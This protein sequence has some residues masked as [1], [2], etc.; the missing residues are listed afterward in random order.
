M[1][2][3]VGKDR[4]MADTAILS[5]SAANAEE[6]SQRGVKLYDDGQRVVYEVRSGGSTTLENGVHPWSSA[7]TEEL[8]Q[9]VGQTFGDQASVTVTRTRPAAAGR[10]QAGTGE[11]TAPA[12]AHRD[13]VLGPRGKRAP[14]PPG[15]GH[16]GEAAQSPPAPAGMAV[17]VVYVG[18]GTPAVLE[19][20]GTAQ[21]DVF[22]ID[23]DDDR[24]LR[25]KT[26]TDVSVTDGNAADLV[27]GRPQ[28]VSSELP[29][30]EKEESSVVELPPPVIQRKKRCRCFSL[31][32]LSDLWVKGTM[33]MEAPFPNTQMENQHI[34]CPANEQNGF[35]NR[36]DSTEGEAMREMVPLDL[37][38]EED[39]CHSA[40][41]INSSGP[42]S[43]GLT[44]IDTSDSQSALVPDIQTAHIKKDEVEGKKSACT[45]EDSYYRNPNGHVKMVGQDCKSPT[46]IKKEA[47][48]ELRAFQEEKPSKLFDCSSEKEPIRVTKVRD[49]E[50]ME[51]LERERQELIHSQAV[52][53]NPGIATKWW[54]PPQIK[55]IEEELD[56]D[57]LES[58]RKYQERKKKLESSNMQQ[59]DASFIP[60]EAIRKEDLLIEERNFSTTQNQLQ[61]EEN[62]VEIRG[63][64]TVVTPELCSG[65][66]FSG[67]AE[68]THAEKSSSSLENTT[69]DHVHSAQEK[70]TEAKTQRADEH[71]TDTTT[72]QARTENELKERKDRR[73]NYGDFTCAQAGVTV[74]EDPEL[75]SANSSCH[76]EEIDSGLDDLSVQSQD[77]APQELL[78]N[79]FSIDNVSDSGASNE[80]T[81]T[82]LENSLGDFSLP[83]TPQAT[84]PV[85]GEMG[86]RTAARS[87]ISTSPSSPR[88]FMT[89]EPVEYHTT[90]PVQKATQQ[91]R[92]TTSWE[93]TESQKESLPNPGRYEEVRNETH[94]GESSGSS[95]GKSCIQQ[96]SQ[97]YDHKSKYDPPQ[98][99]SPVQEK[100]DVAQEIPMKTPPVCNDTFRPLTVGGS[101][102]PQASEKQQFSYFS[103]Y[104]EA[105]ELRSTASLTRHREPE[106]SSVP[107]RLRSHK[108]RTLSRIEEEIRAAQEREQELKRQRQT[109]GPSTAPGHKD[110]TSNVPTRL[111]VTAKTA[112]GK[113]HCVAFTPPGQDCPNSPT[114]SDVSSEGSEGG[115]RPKNF[116]Q[117]LMED[118]EIHKVKRKDKME[119]NR[120]LEATRITRHKS[121]MA[122]QWEAGAYTNQ[123]EEEE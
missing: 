78:S 39:S 12:E 14:A 76:N 121:N 45:D 62:T 80:A 95:D 114:L 44:T 31:A 9:R 122:V 99:S 30:E 96:D 116:M 123:E 97:I 35:A 54:N 83:A 6:L 87:E 43:S 88:T 101:Q 84:S 3:S 90:V 19:F 68:A 23:E 75:S 92:Q 60:E 15:T 103:K 61:L 82:F 40:F 91:A 108:Q 119:D 21:G 50:E 72:E 59:T 47:R 100:Q 29:S 17:T 81:G 26:V 53:K 52:K 63:L 64:Q 42:S 65:N 89:E 107:F 32:L 48:F 117:T 77:T 70:A 106:V 71:P 27:A 18:D 94:L 118:Y 20:D 2:I 66:L 25:E 120:V 8:M 37:A 10:A 41:G 38:L 57:Q 105:A 111:V 110:R 33:E 104:S 22:L 28:S 34:C 5:V 112:P 46:T 1:D 98:A 55:T 16:G 49:S 69:A 93:L 67:G 13:A 4:K 36:R 113:I 86:R 85:D 79:D 51:E 7:E 102:S 115:Q 109:R 74:L 58:H 56:P 24:S 73:E 11:Q